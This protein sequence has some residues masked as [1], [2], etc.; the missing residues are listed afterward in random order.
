MLRKAEA[1]TASTPFHAGKSSKVPLP[2]SKLAAVPGKP[3]YQ[4]SHLKWLRENAGGPSEPSASA[5]IQKIA[6]SASQGQLSSFSKEELRGTPGES[7]DFFE[8]EQVKLNVKFHLD[9]IS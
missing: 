2:N 9:M 8:F 5:S 4:K 1:D 3:Y 7:L 6:S